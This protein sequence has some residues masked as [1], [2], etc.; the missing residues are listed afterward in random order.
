M[1]RK[2][3]D[4]IALCF[5]VCLLIFGL[6][7]L[8]VGKLTNFPFV[9]YLAIVLTAFLAFY[10]IDRLK[11]LDLS[12]MRIVL[13]DIKEEKREIFAKAEAVK[14]LGEKVA[15]MVAYNVAMA[16]RF[17]SDED[18]NDRFNQRKKIEFPRGNWY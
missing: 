6:Y 15:E 14:K 16:N 1:E 17:V 2:M 10:S 11:E 12:K 13:N 18:V 3:S 9:F 4:V 7:F 8:Y 5:L